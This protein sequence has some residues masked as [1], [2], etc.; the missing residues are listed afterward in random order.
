MA[1]ARSID[2]R[3]STA[4]RPPTSR[5]IIESEMSSR[6]GFRSRCF[7]LGFVGIV[8]SSICRQRAS[9]ARVRTMMVVETEANPKHLDC[10][11]FLT[12]GY[13]VGGSAGGPSPAG[14]AGPG[15]GGRY[16]LSPKAP[17]TALHRLYLFIVFNRLRCCWRCIGAASAISLSRSPG[18]TARFL[19]G[20]ALCRSVAT[21]RPPGPLAWCL[22]CA[23][24]S[25][26]P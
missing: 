19:R 8:R 22:S 17:D 16:P 7:C 3:A 21:S 11:D 1:W 24:V 13:G 5:W 10:F 18:N 9:L 15:A 14:S 12:E 2:T 20:C 25:P 4:T 26:W 23:D 6:G